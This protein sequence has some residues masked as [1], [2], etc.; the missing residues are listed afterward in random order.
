MNTEPETVA[1][2]MLDRPDCARG[3]IRMQRTSEGWE[4]DCL[5]PEGERQE[6]NLPA[7]QTR[8]EAID[9]IES[10]WDRATWDL[11]WL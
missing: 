9:A 6:A 1:T 4:V 10:T 2:I 3:E 8:M 11:Q 5:T 7:F